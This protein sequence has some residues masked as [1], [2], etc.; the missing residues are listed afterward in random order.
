M[1]DLIRARPTPWKTV[2]L[3]CGKCARKMRAGYGPSGKETL[4]TALREAFRENG[5]RRDLRIIETRCMGICPRKA[6]TALNASR[7]E[8]IFTIPRGTAATEAMARLVND[9]EQ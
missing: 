1:P 7:P 6:V 3:L 9:A 4:R 2:I 5:H 8:K